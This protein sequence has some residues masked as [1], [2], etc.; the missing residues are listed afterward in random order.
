M[1]LL[2]TYGSISRTINRRSTLMD[3]LTPEKRSWNMSRIRSKNTR[4]ELIVRSILHHLGLRFRLHSTR[5]AGHPD[6]ILPKHNIVVFVHGC[7]WHRHP[8]CRFAYTPK[9]RTDF[10]TKK[11]QGNVDRDRR[12]QD[13]LRQ[14]GWKAIIVWEC[15]V[16]KP[17]F[18]RKR[19]ARRF[20]IETTLVLMDAK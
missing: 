11:F 1:S 14:G 8:K 13:L 17:D 18:L 5:L 10:W 16:A 9:S 2:A 3:T 6:I 15:E 12:Q 4:P 19:L 7:F 20:K